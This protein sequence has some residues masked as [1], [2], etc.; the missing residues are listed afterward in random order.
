MVVGSLVGVV[1]LRFEVGILDGVPPSDV[2][3]ALLGCRC[4]LFVA[5]RLG[6]TPSQLSSDMLLPARLGGRLEGLL[7]GLLAGRLLGR[8]AG[9]PKPDPGGLNR[10]LAGEEVLAD[11]LGSLNPDPLSASLILGADASLLSGVPLCRP[12]GVL[13]TL[14]S[15]IFVIG[16]A[17]GSDDPPA[18]RF[19][20]VPL[21][22][23]CE[24]LGLLDLKGIID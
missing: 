6:V 8:L 20:E 24:L 22:L 19:S 2:W 10:L 17:E 3:L 11:D 16:P 4:K 21:W 14:F 15:R 12:I 5:R 7:P 18:E 1:P 23:D 13:R 9:R